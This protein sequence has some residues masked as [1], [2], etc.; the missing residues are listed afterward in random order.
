MLRMQKMSSYSISTPW[1]IAS[2]NSPKSFLKT[3]KRQ[4]I[5]SQVQSPTLNDRD[6]E[7]VFVWPFENLKHRFIQ[8]TSRILRR[9]EI[10]GPFAFLNHYLSDFVEVSFFYDQDAE[11]MFAWPFDTIKHRFMEFTCLFLRRPKGKLCVLRAIRLLKTSLPRLRTNRIF[12]YSECRKCIRMAFRHYE[13][14]LHRHHLSRILRRSERRLRVLRAFRLLKTSLKRL[15][16]SH[17]FRYQECRKWLHM[18]FRY[19]ETSVHRL[20]QRRFLRLPE[21]WLWVL[22]AIHLL[23]T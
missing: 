2:S 1:N 15:R 18:A 16:P 4:I 3:S 13:T 12:G 21:G 17:F 11:N 5:S 22:R 14:S 23:K 7:N 8:F 19:L 20:Q 9:P 6:A 10:S